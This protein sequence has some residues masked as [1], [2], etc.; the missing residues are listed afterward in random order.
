[1]ISLI[2]LVSCG[3]TKI[4]FDDSIPIDETAI[5][6]P[7]ASVTVVSFNGNR[8][9]WSIGT[10]RGNDYIIPSGEAELTVSIAIKMANTL[11]T[12]GKLN[13]TYDFIS[14]N[15]YM[16]V[17]RGI[18]VKEVEADIEIRNLTTNQRETIKARGK[19]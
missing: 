16:L 1:L 5:I 3:T 10:W 13:F 7:T 6:Q 8:V 12:G 18:N 4:V 2:L 9:N 14:G 11:Y 17:C 19:N 15:K